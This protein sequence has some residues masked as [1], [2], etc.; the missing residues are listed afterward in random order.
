MVR[1]GES[2]NEGE[3]GTDGKEE[4]GDDHECMKLRVRHGL[5]LFAQLDMVYLMTVGEQ[6]SI[7]GCQ[8]RT[9]VKN[10]AQ[11]TVLAAATFSPN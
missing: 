7:S 1:K 2:C 10:S 3:L 6:V 11:G 8:N 4:I 9:G 5:F